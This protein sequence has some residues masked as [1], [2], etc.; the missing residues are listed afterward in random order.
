ML[1]EFV[2]GHRSLDRDGA[3]SQP[4]DVVERQQRMSQV[5]EHAP[6]QHDVELLTEKLG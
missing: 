3:A 5:I 2:I 6:E 1:A 4:T